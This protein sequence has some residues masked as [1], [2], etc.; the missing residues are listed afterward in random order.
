MNAV[1][2]AEECARKLDAYRMARDQFRTAIYD[3]RILPFTQRLMDRL[4][5][6]LERMKL[7]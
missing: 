7:I 6:I 3:E 2:R 4:S 1:D 5:A